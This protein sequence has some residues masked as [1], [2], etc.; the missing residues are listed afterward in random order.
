VL[1]SFRLQK[2]A[3]VSPNK[4]SKKSSTKN[5]QEICVSRSLAPIDNCG[6]WEFECPLVWDGLQTT[7]DQSVRYCKQCKEKVYLATTLK[8]VDAH[9]LQGHC[10][11]FSGEL[12]SG[13]VPGGSII[14]NPVFAREGQSIK[15]VVAGPGGSGKSAFVIQY[16]ANHFVDSYDP[17]I[18]ESYRK[19]LVVDGSTCLLEVLDTAGQEEFSAMRS[20]WFRGGE[21][22]AVTYS[23]TDRTGFEKVHTFLD[24]IYRIRDFDPDSNQPPFILL[25]GLKSDLEEERQLSQAEGLE[26]AVRYNCAWMEA[27]AKT[28]TNLDEAFTALV[29]LARYKKE[30]AEREDERRNR[31]MGKPAITTRGLLRGLLGW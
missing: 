7:A 19:R 11:A 21:V 15:L 1:V 23:I 16:V 26:V 31:K 9:A 4:S 30:K 29:R 8:E 14:S 2:T 5:L 12:D 25:L 17:T 28:R 22:Y 6:K 18:E 20:C 24:E 13:S 27:S 3:K 10:V